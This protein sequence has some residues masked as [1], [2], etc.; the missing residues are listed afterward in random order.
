MAWLQRCSSDYSHADWLQRCSTI[1]TTAGNPKLTTGPCKLTTDPESIITSPD[2]VINYI[3]KFPAPSD[4]ENHHQGLAA[5]LI[6]PLDDRVREYIKT[7]VRNGTRRKTEILSCTQEFVY[8][9]IY[10][11][12][13]RLRRR[14]KPGR[15]TI[16]VQ[17]FEF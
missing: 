4:H 8:N 12:Q 3:T 16:R 14:F 13:C 10:S 17:E 5:G 15:K 9:N 6:K 2:V 7:L 11:G 1:T